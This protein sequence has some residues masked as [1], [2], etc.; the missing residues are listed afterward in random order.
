MQRMMEAATPSEQ[1]AWLLED[2]GNW[3]GTSK[4]WPA[5]GAEAFEEK[6]QFVVR[7][8]LGGRFIETTHRCDMPDMPAFEAIVLTGYDNAAREFVTVWIDSFGTTMMTGTGARSADGKTL[9]LTC[10]YFCPMRG[11]RTTLW[12]SFTRESKDRQT[13]R[14]WSE[15]MATG[16]KYLMAEGVYERQAG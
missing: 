13:H 11:K 10:T 6:A 2:V 16:Q 4:S 7:S 5:P 12:Q 9:A 1:H 3:K 15:D 8:V 14:M